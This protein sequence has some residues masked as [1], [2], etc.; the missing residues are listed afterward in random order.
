VTGALA[1]ETQTRSSHCGLELAERNI[2]VIVDYNKIELGHVA[3]FAQGAG[4]RGAL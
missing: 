4:P 3:H 2:Q 1:P